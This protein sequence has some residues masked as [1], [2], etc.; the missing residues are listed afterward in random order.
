MSFLDDLN[1]FDAHHR[2]NCPQYESVATQL[3]SVGPFSSFEL[4]PFLH[5]SAFKDFELRST[6]ELHR[7]LSS[8]GTSG[9]PSRVFI[10]KADSLAQMRSL[11]RIFTRRFGGRRRQMFVVTED[12]GDLSARHAAV[13]GFTALGKPVSLSKID[14]TITEEEPIVFGMTTDVW[15]H[16]DLMRKFSSVKPIVIHGGGWKRLE[17]LSVS[18]DGFGRSLR[19]LCPRAEI[20]N[21]FG[22][23]EQVGTVYFDCVLGNFHEHEEGKFLIRSEK[24]LEVTDLGLLQL[25]SLVP[26]SYPG[27]SLLTDD[28]CKLVQECGC[29]DKSPAFQY[30]SRR[31]KAPTR[32]CANV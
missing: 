3:F 18:R 27:H 22:M 12:V 24:T 10:D 2:V 13:S 30:V 8:S 31:N 29:G 11:G 26:R 28:V 20:V 9:K 19:E 25:F 7:T 4:F 15:A 21:F 32:G 6:G 16:R 14:Q 17:A 23:V 1:V 5:V